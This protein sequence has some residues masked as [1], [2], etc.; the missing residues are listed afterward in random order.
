[1]KW[2]WQKDSWPNFT[3]DAAS[4][5]KLESDFMFQSGIQLGTLKHIDNKGKSQLIIELASNEA[6]DTSEIEGEFLNRDSVQSSIR[7]NFGLQ[8]DSRKASPAEQGIAELMADL[9]HN[10]DK[11]LTHAM[12]FRW[13]KMIF[14][15]RRDLNDIGCYRT[16]SEAM[17]V[18]SGYMHAPKVHFEAPPSSQVKE[19]MERFINWFN[20]SRKMSILTRASIAHLYFVSIHPFED[21]NGR[22]ARALAEKALSQGLEQPALIA[23]SSTILKRR[24][25]YYNALEHSNKNN[26]ITDWI[27]YFATTILESQKY[28][29]SMIDFLIAKTKLYDRFKHLLNP[30][31][32]KVV[33]KLFQAG[34]DGFKGGLSADN[35]ISI[36]NTSRATATRDLTHL[37]KIGVLRKTGELKSTRYHL[38]LN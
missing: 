29:M 37:V 35:Y 26:E 11:S 31:E 25:A 7:R 9:F 34:V 3:Y 8:D 27:I 14:S 12:L 28:T 13:H 36:T 4:I 16:H 5:D 2:N 19:E 1:M 18:V 17:Q 38:V 10:Y 20:N 33:D 6:L 32:K 15:G 24:K 22:I 23:L 21:G 30:R